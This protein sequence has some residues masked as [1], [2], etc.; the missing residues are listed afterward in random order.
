[1][2]SRLI[3]SPY[4]ISGANVVV[5]GSTAAYIHY[6]AKDLS[7]TIKNMHGEQLGRMKEL[8]KTIENMNKK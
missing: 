4:F 3:N 7:K 2:L 6:Q 8:S 5:F 1:M